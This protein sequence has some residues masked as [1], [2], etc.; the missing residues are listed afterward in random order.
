MNKPQFNDYVSLAVLLMMVVAFVSGQGDARVQAAQAAFHSAIGISERFS[1]E[2][3][4][5]VGAEAAVGR[6]NL[7]VEPRHFRGEDE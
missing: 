6:L 7:T 3:E 1:V 5:L 2:F 4:D